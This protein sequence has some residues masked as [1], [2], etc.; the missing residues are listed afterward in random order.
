VLAAT[1]GLTAATSKHRVRNRRPARGNWVGR[2]NVS[3]IV[4]RSLVFVGAFA[5]AAAQPIATLAAPVASS[6]HSHPAAPAPHAAPRDT[7]GSLGDFN[8]PSHFDGQMKP[9]TMPQHFTL[10]S[11]ARFNSL[12]LSTYRRNDW[13]A[14]PGNL[15]YPALLSPA[16]AANTFASAPSQQPPSEFT[17]GSLVDGKSKLFSSPNYGDALTS[18]NGGTASSAPPALTI[19]FSPASCGAPGFTSL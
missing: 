12:P 15:W 14:T 5:L 18:T 7:S 9:L 4:N 11:S 8:A 19:G 6:A 1:A 16:C 17:L 3:V 2:K 13:L 10:G